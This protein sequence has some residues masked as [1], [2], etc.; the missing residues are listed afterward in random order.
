[1]KSEKK[2]ARITGILYLIIFFAN[3]FAYFYVSES[4]I[5]AGDATATANN[6]MA[7]E[8]LYRGGLVS[9]LIVF[10]ERHWRS[11]SALWAA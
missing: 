7:S 2:T 4:L 10:F 9:Y 6:I 5:V 3:M 11:C 8:S 1:M